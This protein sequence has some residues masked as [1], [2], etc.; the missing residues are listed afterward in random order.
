MEIKINH[1]SKK[2]PK[3]RFNQKTKKFEIVYN[4][5]VYREIETSLNI[6]SHNSLPSSSQL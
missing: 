3:L 5:E 6:R 1:D 2:K 4:V